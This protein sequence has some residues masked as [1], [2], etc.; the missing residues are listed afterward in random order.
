M[1]SMRVVLVIV[2]HKGLAVEQLDVNFAYLH[3][4]MDTEVYITQP[5]G[6]KDLNN[7]KKVCLLNKGLYGIK[8]AGRI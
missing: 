3:G 8:Q 1:I 4:L 5:P 7:A 6:F 2:A